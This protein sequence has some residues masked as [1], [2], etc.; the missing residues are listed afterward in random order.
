[1]SIRA[2]H[3]TKNF[4][5]F[6]ALHDISVNIPSGQ[7]TALLGPSG[8]GKTTLLRII[9][10]LDTPDTGQVHS[11]GVDLTNTPAR[12]RGIGFVFQHYAPFTHMT[13]WDN[14]AFGL[15]VAR[16]PRPHIRERVGELLGL[17][18]LDGL[19]G[20]YPGELSGGQRQ[21]MALARAL[22]IQP[23]LLLLDEPFG[24][25]DVR[26]RQQLRDWLRD[27][28][29]RIGVT[30]VFV[31]HDQEEA[32]ELADQIVVINGGRVEQAGAPTELY[33]RPTNE[34]VMSF[35]GP[36]TRLGDTLIRPHDIEIHQDPLTNT[37]EAMIERIVDLG[38]HSRVE[39][40]LPD[41]SRATVHTTRSELRQI[42]ASTG[43]IVFLRATTGTT[44][45]SG[46]DG[47]YGRADRIRTEA[48][49]S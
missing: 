35:L 10:G 19:S 45:S 36:T 32:M 6:R 16:T 18:G 25:L 28:H 5:D 38:H 43:D 8:G 27:L 4:G 1:M 26:V 13:V 47:G 34:F 15:K 11:G 9:A 37:H 46:A 30:T 39:T 12:R 41:G 3:I 31:T 22:A 7:L 20:R 24:A 23:R 21:R 33:D 14:V 40:V 42:E 2:H 29:E 49:A 44:G 17:V 48:R